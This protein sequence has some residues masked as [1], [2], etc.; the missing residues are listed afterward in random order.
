MKASELAVKLGG[1]LE[2]EDVELM[3]LEKGFFA[4]LFKGREGNR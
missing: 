4:K 1:V 2:G 3:K